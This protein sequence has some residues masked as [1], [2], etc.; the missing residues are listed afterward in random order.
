MFFE[1]IWRFCEFLSLRDSAILQIFMRFAESSAKILQILRFYKFSCDL[2][3]LVHFIDKLI[4][5]ALF[6]KFSCDSQNLHLFP[7]PCGGG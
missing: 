6:C 2:Q 4:D 5:S 1:N 3:N 7:L